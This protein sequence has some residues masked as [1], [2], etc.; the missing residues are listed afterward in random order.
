MK[1][2]SRMLALLCVIA[3]TV[4]LPLQ[5]FA[6]TPSAYAGQT[7]EDTTI[8]LA[9]IADSD[10]TLGK[11]LDIVGSVYSNGT[12]YAEQQAE[13]NVEGL[14]ISGTKNETQYVPDWTN[15]ANNNWVPEKNYLDGYILLDAYG[16]IAQED[17]EYLGKPNYEGAIYDPETSFDYSVPSPLYTTPEVSNVIPYMEANANGD[18]N[19]RNTSVTISESTRINELALEGEALTVDLS[20]GD[21]VLVIDKLTMGSNTPGFIITGTEGNDNQLYLYIN[22][23]TADVFEVIANYNDAEHRYYATGDTDEAIAWMDEAGDPDRLKLYITKENAVIGACHVSGDIYFNSNSVDFSGASLFNGHL[24]T[25]ADEFKTTGAAFFR[26]VVMAPNAA[27][28]VANGGT[29]L[30]QLYT[31]TLDMEGWGRILYMPSRLYPSKVPEPS[32]DPD[33]TAVPTETPAVDEGEPAYIVRYVV[34]TGEYTRGTMDTKMHKPARGLDKDGNQEAELEYEVLDET[35]YQ[36]TGPQ[37]VSDEIKERVQ[38]ILNTTDDVFV[39]RGSEGLIQRERFGRID[40][41][42]QDMS[43]SITPYAYPRMSDKID[44]MYLCWGDRNSQVETVW[45]VIPEELR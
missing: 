40:F 32:V 36:I 9:V 13:I 15:A 31:D 11:G 41:N 34:A 4:V 45:Y 38:L 2:L 24:T 7:Y 10:V 16:N 30:G 5:A 3:M 14:F 28:Y 12:I 33:P 44:T 39:Q 20:N 42:G 25:N 29:I 21:V 6:A 22:D 19:A 8:N 27:S 1:K 43:L 26:G 23:Y 17:T 18:T 35:T 37:Y